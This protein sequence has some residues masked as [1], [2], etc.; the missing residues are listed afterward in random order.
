[1][2]TAPSRVHENVEEE[3]KTKT[4]VTVDE[5]ALLD[6]AWDGRTEDVKKLLEKGVNPNC[7]NPVSLAERRKQ[8]E[9]V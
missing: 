5:R 2:G 3:A 4:T 8:V 6:A 9:G 1:M 7:R